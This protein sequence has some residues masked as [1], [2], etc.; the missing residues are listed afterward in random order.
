MTRPQLSNLE[1]ELLQLG[2]TS[3]ETTT[4][5]HEEMLESPLERSVVESALLGLVDRA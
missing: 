4:T 3:P 2:S 5:L 1:H